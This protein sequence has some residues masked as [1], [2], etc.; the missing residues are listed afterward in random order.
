ME[1]DLEGL[2]DR[3]N[4]SLRLQ[5][6]ATFIDENQCRISFSDMGFGEIFPETGFFKEITVTLGGSN[7]QFST[8][9]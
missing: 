3:K 4:Y 2:A 9:S 6:Q 5:V 1:V 7:E 8:L